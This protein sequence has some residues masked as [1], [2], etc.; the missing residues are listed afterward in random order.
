M[1][2]DAPQLFI[3]ADSRAQIARWNSAARADHRSRSEWAK[4]ALDAV[5]ALGLDRVE[6]LV[7]KELEKR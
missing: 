4:L 3:R 7:K 6:A 2:S 1:A 5:A